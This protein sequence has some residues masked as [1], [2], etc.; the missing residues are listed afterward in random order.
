MVLCV[1]G[2]HHT[3]KVLAK[4]KTKFVETAAHV[5]KP[6]NCFIDI[7]RGKLVQLFVMP[8]DNHCDINRAQN[9]KLMSLL[10]K[11]A[12]AFEKSPMRA[13]LAGRPRRMDSYSIVVGF[14][15]LID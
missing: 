7:P 10:E 1:R 12:F 13:V 14:F 3:G 11:P 2:L 5:L 4:T 8:K 9:G 6:S 15:G